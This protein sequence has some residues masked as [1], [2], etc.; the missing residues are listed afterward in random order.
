MS[1]FA[2][3]YPLS[4]I[5]EMMEEEKINEKAWEGQQI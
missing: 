5:I 2:G 1:V 3:I 4:M